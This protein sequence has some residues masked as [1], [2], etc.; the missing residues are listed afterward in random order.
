[1]RPE[2]LVSEISHWSRRESN[3]RPSRLFCT[4]VWRQR[5]KVWNIN[6]SLSYFNV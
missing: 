3:P 1:V 6:Q 2:G 4:R 5:E